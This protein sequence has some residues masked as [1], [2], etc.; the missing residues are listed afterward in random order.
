MVGL[1]A[2]SMMAAATAAPA[3]TPHMTV[4]AS[5]RATVRIM[6]A[7]KISL[8]AEPQPDGLVMKPAQVT[9]E[10]GTKHDAQL[11]EFQ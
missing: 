10:D 8:S 2:L 6:S 3:A 4:T 9:I 1:I 11:V 5:A 7:A